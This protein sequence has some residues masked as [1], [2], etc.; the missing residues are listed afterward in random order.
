MKHKQGLIFSLDAAIAV[1]VVII[2]I[3]NSSYYT[4]TSNRESV[5]QLQLVKLGNDVMKVLH[6]SGIL[7][8]AVLA[9]YN[10]ERSEGS[11][12]KE[13]DLNFSSYIPLGYDMKFTITDLKES[14]VNKTTCSGIGCLVGCNDNGCS[15]KDLLF[16]TLDIERDGV[17][18]IEVGYT[19]KAP[20]NIGLVNVT[21]NDVTEPN[22]QLNITRHTIP[23]IPAPF[24]FTPGINELE[25]DA[26]DLDL[27]WF[28][29]IGSAAY[30]AS[31]NKTVPTDRFVGTGQRVFSTDNNGEFI[32]LNIVR[33]HIWLK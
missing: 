11:W 27:N 8:E 4:S 33:F 7:K 29:I 19:D 9:D 32:S 10:A 23:V 21:V 13:E 31:T 24:N 14:I 15:G 16:N 3:I 30:A 17:F 26:S 1:T 18:Y 25:F 2:M 6:I 28:R 5:S 20:F 12:I 22:S